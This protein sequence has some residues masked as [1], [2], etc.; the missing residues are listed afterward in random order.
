MPIVAGLV[1]LA[2]TNTFLHAEVTEL[3]VR[4]ALT[5]LFNRRHLDATVARLEAARE[6]RR[7]KARATAP[8]SRSSTSTTSARSTSAT[9]TRPATR[10]CAPSPRSSGRASAARTSSPA[11]AARSSSR[12]STGRRSSRRPRS[13]RRSGPPSGWSRSRARTASPISATVS[14]GCAAL[15]DPD[16]RFEDIVARADVGLVLAKRAGRNRVIAA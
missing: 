8:R 12:S 5:G 15:A 2:I 13:P 16:E 9:A 14:A 6:R 3:S 11:T 1:A 10:S 4:D 7:P